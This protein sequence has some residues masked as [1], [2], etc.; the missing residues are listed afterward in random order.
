M[1]FGVDNFFKEN[2]PLSMPVSLGT[3][4]FDFSV[5]VVLAIVVA[6]SAV[7]TAGSGVVPSSTV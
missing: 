2:M 6:V 5:E 3:N 1:I 4:Y 7:F